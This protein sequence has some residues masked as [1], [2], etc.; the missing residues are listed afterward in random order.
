V[1]LLLARKEIQINQ[2][3]ENGVTPLFCACQDGHVDVVRLLLARKEIQIH[4][5]ADGTTPLFMASL[6]GHNEIV[7]LL[8][9]HRNRTSYMY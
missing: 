1:R 3:T 2:A 9:Q 5:A 4:P 7:T 6:N 8:Q